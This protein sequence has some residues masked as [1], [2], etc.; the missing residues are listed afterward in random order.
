MKTIIF[1]ALCLLYWIGI[2]ILSVV[3]NAREYPG[4][5][6]GVSLL[7]YL[8]MPLF[9]FGAGIGLN[10]LAQH[11][12]YWVVGITHVGYLIYGITYVLRAKPHK[13]ATA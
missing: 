11:L 12:G 4:E 13:S 10:A 5:K 1:A 8:I 9:V 7:P 2:A 6:K 3:Q